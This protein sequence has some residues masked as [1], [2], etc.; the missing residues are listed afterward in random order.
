MG[1][2]VRQKSWRTP[3][4][5]YKVE[6]ALGKTD[7]TVMRPA[8]RFRGDV[9]TSR[10]PGLLLVPRAV[11]FLRDSGPVVWAR[12]ALRW[13]EVP[14]R[15]GRSSPRQ[16]EIVEGLAEGDRLSPIDLAAATSE[17]RQASGAR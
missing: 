7:P 8:M 13:S 12:R 14:V 10:T 5:G 1:R 2:T 16:V 9:E 17:T 4:K 3:V 6:V 11:V 15:L